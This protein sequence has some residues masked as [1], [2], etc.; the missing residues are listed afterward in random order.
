MGGTAAAGPVTPGPP[1]RPVRR[2]RGTVLAGALALLVGASVTVAVVVGGPSPGNAGQQ[3]GDMVSR[4]VKAQALVRQAEAGVCREAAP[5]AASRRGAVAAL[6]TAR[7][8]DLSVTA[9]L[10]TG[11]GSTMAGAGL[12]VVAGELRRLASASAGVSSD[13]AQWASDRQVAGCYSAPGNDV[14][15]QRAKAVEEATA[16]LAQD[17]ARRWAQVALR[18]HLPSFDAAQL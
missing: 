11:P 10:A 14:F 9:S 13:L 17:F 1:A 15:Y 5:G 16:P 3:I 2:R 8:L 12:S 6:S 18:W 4:T 7:S